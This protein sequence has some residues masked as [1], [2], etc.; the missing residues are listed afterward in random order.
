ME[1]IVIAGTVG[2]LATAKKLVDFARYAANLGRDPLARSS[3]VTQ[4]CAW[5]G[6][7]AA[8]FLYGAS[9]YGARVDVDGLAVS[10][11]NGWTKLLTGLAVGSLASLVAD[12]TRA[13]D[14]K[15]SAVVPP[16]LAP[17]TKAKK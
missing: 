3:V 8:V 7:V 17:K 16:L 14:D 9:Q 6:S 4:A 1:T 12:Y 2:L 10:D 11:M 13:R 15:D 5:A